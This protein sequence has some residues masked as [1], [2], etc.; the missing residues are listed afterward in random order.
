MRPFAIAAAALLLLQPQPGLAQATEIPPS[1]ALVERLLAALPD[2]AEIDA[3]DTEVDAAELGAL[4]ALNPGKEAEIRSI[5]EANLACSGK[6]ISAGTL[7]M[8]RTVARDLGEARVKRLIS[9]YEGPDY[10]AFAALG[11]HMA[12]AA[13]PSPED[14]AALAKLMEA[15][16]LQA[17][18]DRMNQAQQIFEADQGFMSAAMKCAEEQMAALEAAGLKSR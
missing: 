4:V 8:L 12:G 10:T 3:I 11:L 15:Y 2:R 1:E 18:L 16:P 7:R 6:A 5:L 17:W 13:A 9:F 14:R